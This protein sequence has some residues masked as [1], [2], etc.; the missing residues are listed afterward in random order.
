MSLDET[1]PNPKRDGYTNTHD[2]D[3]SGGVPLY[4]NREGII[5]VGQKPP[6]SFASEI[7]VLTHN[8]HSH[9]K[10]ARLPHSVVPVCQRL[11]TIPLGSFQP[12][13]PRYS[14]IS[15]TYQPARSVP[16]FSKVPRWRINKWYRYVSV[17]PAQRTTSCPT[18]KTSMPMGRWSGSP[19]RS[20]AREQLLQATIDGSPP[21]ERARMRSAM[22]V[23]KYQAKELPAPEPTEPYLL[24]ASLQ[25]SR[26]PSP[27]PLLVVIDLNGTLLARKRASKNYTPRPT[28]EKFLKYCMENHSVMIWSSA[29]IVNVDCLCGQIFTADQRRQLLGVWGRE[30]LDLTKIQY[31]E[32]VQVY[33]RLNRI[34]SDSTIQ[35]RH[36]RFR[37]GGRWSQANTVLVD[38]TLLKAKK[39]PYNL[40]AVP[41]FSKGEGEE[42]VGKEVLG[43]VMAYLEEVK[44]WSDVSSFMNKSKFEVDNGWNWK[45]E[46]GP[47]QPRIE[48][49]LQGHPEEGI[50]TRSLQES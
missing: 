40:V 8:N 27:Q 9:S 30:S 50:E 23:T 33:K 21:L 15:T 5:N 1:T 17:V 49:R 34:W 10:Q 4:P 14:P 7:S 20:K 3:S 22:P 28:M 11:T 19:P 13:G 37:Q 42:K 12:M 26:L 38:D 2:D 16:A 39:H 31:N 6:R 18:E 29:R 43:Q 48:C 41:E 46:Q 24:Q 47:S 32:K 25:P 35:S 36:P 44:N 45:G